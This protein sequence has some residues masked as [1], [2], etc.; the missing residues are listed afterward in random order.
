MSIK[1]EIVANP[2]RGPMR[3]QI[4]DAM[5]ALGFMRETGDDEVINAPP[6]STMQAFIDANGGP[7]GEMLAA[8]EAQ[9]V[10]DNAEAPKPEPAKRTRKKAEPQI[11]ASPENRVPPPEPEAAAQDAADEQ[12]EVE[13]TTKLNAPLTLDDLR[14]AMGRYVEKFGMAELQEDGVQ[15]LSDALGKPPAGEEAW[16]MTVIAAVG[17]DAIAKAVA[18]W[19]AAA[20]AP[21]RYK[22][23]G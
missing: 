17:Q 6:S 7:M 5:S 14:N 18:A 16:K 1:I 20:A 13:A 15:L 2:D 9:E 8:A 4:D 3:A 12:A 23:R 22:G 19:S 11:S 10:I 21:E